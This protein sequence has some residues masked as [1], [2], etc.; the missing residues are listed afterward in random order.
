VL[1]LSAADGG[2]PLDVVTRIAE[3]VAAAVRAAVG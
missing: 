3:D 1:I 2:H